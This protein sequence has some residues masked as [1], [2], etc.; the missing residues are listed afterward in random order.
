M[1]ATKSIDDMEWI[2]LEEAFRQN[3]TNVDGVVYLLKIGTWAETDLDSEKLDQ[4][5]GDTE[6]KVGI[7]NALFQR[8]LTIHLELLRSSKAC[9]GG[10]KSQLRA[11]AK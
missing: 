7:C 3:I 9:G 2:D 8:L 6:E 11:C 4:L 10:C 5:L 1:E